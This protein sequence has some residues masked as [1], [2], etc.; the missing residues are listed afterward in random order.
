MKSVPVL[1]LIIAACTAA[2]V[3]QQETI[4]DQ[5]S[6]MDELVPAMNN[7]QAILKKDSRVGYLDFT[8]RDEFLPWCRCLLAPVMLTPY[9]SSSSADTLLTI[10]RTGDQ[11]AAAKAAACTGSKVLYSYADSSFHYTLLKIR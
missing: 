3:V 7:L 4:I 9:D 10:Y 1:L 11:Q 6:G 5:P 2:A 8:G